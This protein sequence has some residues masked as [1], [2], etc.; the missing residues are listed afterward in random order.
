MQRRARVQGSIQEQYMP[1][2]RRGSGMYG[3]DG[4]NFSWL[5]R[6]PIES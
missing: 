2:G 1:A 5:V 6:P 3:I 4:G